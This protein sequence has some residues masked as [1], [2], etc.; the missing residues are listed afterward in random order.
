[1]PLMKTPDGKFWWISQTTDA[2]GMP[3]PQ[4]IVP[5]NGNTENRSSWNPASVDGEIK[6]GKYIDY[7]EGVTWKTYT[8]QQ[9]APQ[10]SGQPAVDNTDILA[11]L[12]RL[13]ELVDKYNKLKPKTESN[14]DIE[15][16]LLESFGYTTINEITWND[17]TSAGGEAWQRAKNFGGKVLSKAAFPVA[18]A[19]TVWEG[20]QQIQALPPVPAITQEDRNKEITKIISKLIAEFGTFWVGGIIG[21][22]MGG[23]L[24]GVGAIPGFILGGC[25]SQYLLGDDVNSIVDKIVEF[26]HKKDDANTQPAA[27]QQADNQQAPAEKPVV[28]QSSAKGDPDVAE[29]QTSLQQSGATNQDGSPLTIDGIM[30][31]NTITAMQK[32]LAELGATNQ[33]GSPLTIDGRLGPNTAAAIQKYYLS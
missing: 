13:E 29:L 3:G 17:I 25:A 7:P 23:V 2:S 26:L 19:A 18:A 8:Q 12:K 27:G 22:A 9:S 24:G 14:I 28:P 4:G 15:L 30:G 10:Q 1:M 16:A 31:P 11:K 20:W 5:W 32:E 21:G 33:D 6:D